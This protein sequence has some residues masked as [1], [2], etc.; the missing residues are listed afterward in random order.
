M[1]HPS[2]VQIPLI[3]NAKNTNSQLLFALTVTTSVITY[4]LN[5]SEVKQVIDAKLNDRPYN[6]KQFLYYHLNR[7]YFNIKKFIL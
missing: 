4:T 5:P 3:G 1:E 7:N 2:A 6:E